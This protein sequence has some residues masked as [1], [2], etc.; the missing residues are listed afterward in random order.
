MVGSDHR[1][2]SAAL[3]LTTSAETAATAAAH[4]ALDAPRSDHEVKILLV[5][6]H[7][8]PRTSALVNKLRELGRQ[9]TYSWASGGVRSLLHAPDYLGELC[10]AL[11]AHYPLA[12]DTPTALQ[13]ERR[14]LEMEEGL[15]GRHLSG[16]ARRSSSKASLAGASLLHD[17]AQNSRW[18]H[19][20]PLESSDRSSSIGRRIWGGIGGSGSGGR[21]TTPVRSAWSERDDVAA[22]GQGE[23][24]FTIKASVVGLPLYVLLRSQ[25]TGAGGGTGRFVPARHNRRPGAE[26]AGA[27]AAAR[28]CWARRL[29]PGRGGGGP[30][31][32]GAD[33]RG[34]LPR[35]K[36]GR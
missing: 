25:R 35:G 28:R 32:D 34:H 27:E 20:L 1:P 26:G 5:K 31:G 8:L 22:A 11:Y 14:A 13:A 18:V 10:S 6:P 9:L 3:H 23:R 24:A 7:Y 19:E 17:E 33:A 29:V 36:A 15:M 30:E 21:A 12:M 16:K 4:A 2:V